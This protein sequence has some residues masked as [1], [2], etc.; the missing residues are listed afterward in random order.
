MRQQHRP[1]L[2]TSGWSLAPASISDMPDWGRMLRAGA[3]A[4]AGVA[5]A[6]IGRE[7]PTMVFHVM[8]E[9]DDLPR[10]AGLAVPPRPLGDDVGDE[11]AVM[12]GGQRER[13]GDYRR[14]GSAAGA[15]R[16]SGW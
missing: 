7:F 2:S 5:L 11:D 12:I 1:A 3:P 10:G 9:P 15:V 16:A 13:P 6:N 14:G 4:Y 8:S